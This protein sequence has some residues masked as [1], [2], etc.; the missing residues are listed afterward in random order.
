[1]MAKKV[2]FN[3]EGMHCQSCA[4]KITQSLEELEQKYELSIDVPAR[5]VSVQ[6]DP[7]ESSAM[8]FKKQIEEA[9]FKV[10]K[11]QSSEV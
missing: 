2:T 3:V 6:F 1:M 4:Q 8:L 10:D 11:M 9:G 5:S 7:S